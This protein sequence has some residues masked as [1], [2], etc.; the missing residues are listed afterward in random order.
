MLG[1]AHAQES[2]GTVAG[3][4]DPD[5]VKNMHFLH[6]ISEHG[7][8]FGTTAEFEYRKGVFLDKDARIRAFNDE[9]S[10]DT[11]YTLSHNKFSLLT[12]EEW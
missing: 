10:A 6:Y 11:G 8:E 9:Q 5:V 1:L 3:R 12:D 2:D 7:I 4:K